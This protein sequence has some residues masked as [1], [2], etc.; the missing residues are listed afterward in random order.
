MAYFRKKYVLI[1]LLYV[2][3]WLI[4]IF[5]IMPHIFRGLA[6]SCFYHQSSNRPDEVTKENALRADLAHN[7]FAS[8]N[9]HY[10]FERINL[11]DLD[12]C[13]VVLTK[14]RRANPRYLSQ[15]VA[16]IAGQL[17]NFKSTRYSFAVYNV[18]GDEHKEAIEIAKF[19]P[20]VHNKTI[21]LHNGD[22]YDS[23]RMGYTSAMQWC[24]LKNASYN[25]I[26]EDDVFA[27]NRFVSNLLFILNHC[28]R[29]KRG[30]EWGLLKLYYPEKYQ[31]WGNSVSNIVEFVMF[32][33]LFSFL[34]T[35]LSAFVFF[36]PI[37]IDAKTYRIISVKRHVL[38]FRFIFTTVCVIFVL[39]S[40]GRAHWEELRKISPL[41]ISVVEAKGCCIPAVLYPRT[42]FEELIQFLNSRRST[43]LL[44]HDLA[45]DQFIEE[46]GLRKLL[47]VPNLVNHLGMIS[48][49]RVKGQKRVSEFDLLFPPHFTS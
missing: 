45:I 27:S 14:Q 11:T 46:R 37:V 25:L 9:F 23:Q 20:V 15:T 22:E 3:V 1:E 18:G 35:C 24:L 19:V 4:A 17:R 36:G 26:L 6:Y 34:F 28:I 2:V 49:L 8:S 40:L 42:H 16:S 33:L 41:M 21:P 13:I 38:Y 43:K 48:S 31:G 30:E 5:V 39:L 12:V 47:A 7:I 32:S 44:P 10:L 29:D